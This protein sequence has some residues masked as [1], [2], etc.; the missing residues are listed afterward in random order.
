MGPVARVGAC[1]DSSVVAAAEV[2]AATE[3]EDFVD[4]NGN[5]NG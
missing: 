4:N 1:A 3:A 2:T 5:V